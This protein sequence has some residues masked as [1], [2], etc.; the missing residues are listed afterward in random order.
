MRLNSAVFHIGGSLM[1]EKPWMLAFGWLFAAI[2]PVV[3][4][5]YLKEL[6]FAWYWKDRSETELPVAA[7]LPVEVA[8]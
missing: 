4:A 7:E 6:A 3:L 2:P 5:N 1:R 8:L